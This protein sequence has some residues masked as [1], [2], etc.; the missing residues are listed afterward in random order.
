MSKSE[1]NPNDQISNDQHCFENLEIRILNLFRASDFVLR[2]YLFPFH[3]NFGFLAAHTSSSLL[4]F[5]L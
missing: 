1:T 5:T 4:T 3:F 2:I